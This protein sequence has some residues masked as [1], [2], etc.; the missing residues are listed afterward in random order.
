M[1]KPSW[2]SRGGNV[3][4]VNFLLGE[5]ERVKADHRICGA[6]VI[7]HWSMRRI[8]PLQRWVNL[9]FWYTGVAD[10]SRYTQTKISEDD[11][12]DRVLELL[13]NVPGTASIAGTFSAV[14]H[15][16]EVLF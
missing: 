6:S 12:M 13:K 16:R 3:D 11:L 4:Q 2:N 7:V 1:K 14:R 10:P 9:G 15:P 8:Q 5:I